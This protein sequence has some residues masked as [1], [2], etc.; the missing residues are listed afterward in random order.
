MANS[1]ISKFGE[2]RFERMISEVEDYAII[3][4]DPSGIIS[5]WNKGAEK[6][7]GYQA[8]EIIGK[9]YTVFYPKSDVQADLPK[10]LLQRAA[11]EGKANHE[12][13]RVRKDGS[14]FWGNITITALHREDGTINGYLKVTRDLTERKIA[15]E[16]LKKADEELR[17]KSVELEQIN[18]DL[19]QL[20]NELSSFAYVVS[21]DFK[22][23]IR[24][25]QIF[26]KRQLEEGKTVDEIRGFSEKIIAS[27]E[28]MQNLMEALL[29][30]SRVS[31]DPTNLE[32]I[33]LNEILEAVK[34]DLEMNITETHAKITGDH[35]PAIKGVSYQFHQLFL[36]LISN[37]IKFSRPGESPS[38]I[39]TS[40]IVPQAEI[41]LE[42]QGKNNSYYRISVTDNGVGFDPEQ[43]NRIFDVFQRLNNKNLASGTGIGLAIVK[44]AVLNHGGLVIAQ[45]KPNEGATFHLYLPAE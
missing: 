43:S 16:E 11:Q 34:V 17:D 20:N 3:L 31:N 18:N 21:H 23:P 10:H 1:T 5:T 44:R 41:P 38:I 29:S 39:I 4:L 30:Y 2:E 6:I 13:W 40:K 12:G 28:R 36:N 32:H 25:I 27:A 8:A 7:K 35:L 15:E 14:R 37:S 26:G 42:L 22:E 19:H 45:S 9:S 24:K 33:D